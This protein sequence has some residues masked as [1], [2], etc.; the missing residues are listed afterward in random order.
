MI[1]VPELRT[2]E[3]VLPFDLALLEHRPHC[4]AHLFFISVPFGAI[5]LTKARLQRDPDGI[6][7]FDRIRNQRAKPERRNL[8]RA[9]IERYFC[10]AKAIGVTHKTIASVQS[11]SESTL[12]NLFE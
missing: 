12:T 5:E 2:D 1:V 4:F 7:C 6:F 11:H 9:I 3:D 10:I 8:T